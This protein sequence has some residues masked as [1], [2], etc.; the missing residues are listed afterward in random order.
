MIGSISS[1]N[2]F[3]NLSKE[4]GSASFSNEELK[5]IVINLENDIADGTWLRKNYAYTD[6]Q[7]MPALITQAKTKYPGI[8]LNFVTSPQDLPVEIKNAIEQGI[9][10][11]RFIVN[12]GEG[13]IHFC[14][15]D[16]KHINGKTSLILFEPTSFNGMG[17]AILALRTKMAIERDPLPDCHFSMVEMDIQRSSSECGVFSLALAKKLHIEKDKLLKLHTDNINGTLCDSRRHLPHDKLDAYLPVTFYKHTQGERRLNEYLNMNPQEMSTVVNKKN[18]TILHRFNNNL[19]VTD[20]KE[21]SISVHKKRITEYKAL[22]K[23]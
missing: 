10:S 20:G 19:A 1:V 14:V 18:E 7:V 16:H 23:P 12:M 5:S 15:I 11:S 8:N 4:W 3:D 6:I 21:L 13:G 2:V 9:E 17:P 22:L